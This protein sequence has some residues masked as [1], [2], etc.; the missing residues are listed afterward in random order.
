MTLLA[1]PMAQKKFTS[2][3]EIVVEA[4]L[5]ALIA[6]SAPHPLFSCNPSRF[7]RR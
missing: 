4:A 5:Q 3:F 7:R 2:L 1:R 6:T